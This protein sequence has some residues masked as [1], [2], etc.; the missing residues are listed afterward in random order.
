VHWIIHRRGA[1]Y[2]LYFT[3]GRFRVGRAHPCNG[4]SNPGLIPFS[5]SPSHGADNLTVESISIS[6]VKKRMVRPTPSHYSLRTHLCTYHSYTKYYRSEESSSMTWWR[7]EWCKFLNLSN[8]YKIVFY[9]I[10]SIW[11]IYC[12]SVN[13]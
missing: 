11:F 9:F 3:L 1:L 12:L 5:P 6:S 4:Q 2:T 10:P 13:K 8:N 7:G